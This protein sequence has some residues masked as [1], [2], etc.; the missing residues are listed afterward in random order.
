MKLLIFLVLCLF[1]VW[2]VSETSFAFADGAAGHANTSDHHAVAHPFLTHM[3]LPDAPGEINI[4]TNSILQD[5]ENGNRADFGTHLEA[6]IV[7]RLGLHLRNDGFED[8]NFSEAMLQ[9]A[10]LRNHAKTSGI[11][12]F[13]QMNIRNSRAATD[14]LQGALGISAK[15]L[16]WDRVGI[17]GN[18]HYNLNEDAWEIETAAVLGISDRFFPLLEI[19]GEIHDN[20]QS[21]YLLP[22]VKVKVYKDVYL[23]L[24][25]QF[26]VTTDREFDLQGLG[27][28]DLS[29]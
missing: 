6:G 7:D 13:G 25:V 11:S 27:Q 24:G 22:G 4:R 1:E 28:V 9:Y 23:G 3:G 20:E 29:F 8:R 18:V 14:S 12:V 10:V 17:D 21:L 26:P 16:L 15:T 5:A 2:S 19:R